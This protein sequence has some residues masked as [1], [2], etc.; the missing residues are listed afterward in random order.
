[1]SVEA[2]TVGRPTRTRL[3]AACFLGI[4]TGLVA[5]TSLEAM[6]VPLQN[7]FV[8]SVDDINVLVLAVSAGS[9]LILFAAG[10][11]A[12]R[13]GPRRILTLGVIINL[14]GAVLVAS[15]SG[16]PWLMAGR[17][18][19]GIGGTAMGVSSM[20]ILNATFT[21][22][23]ERAYV[24]GLFAAVIGLT[25]TISPV[26]GG[27]VAQHLTWRLVPVLWIAVS[28][29]ALLFMRG[30]PT[31]APQSEDP[32]EMVTP[33]AAGVT[34]SAVCVAALVAKVGATYSAI[35]LLVAAGA[36]VVL[37]LQWRKMRSHGAQPSLDVSMFT[38]PGSRWLMGAM[39]TVGVVNLFFYCNLFL[40]YRFGLSASHTAGL[41][42]IPQAA[43]IAGGLLGGWISSRIGST[44]T[45]AAA[46][47][48]GCVSA[49]AFL[50]VGE[51]SGFWPVV[52]LLALFA[53][54]GG[55]ITGTLTKAF[56]DCAKPTSSGAASSWR[57]AGWSLGSTL[58]GVATGAIVFTY[59][60]RLWQTKL[61]NVGV[62]QETARWA[63]ESVRG[64]V[65]LTQIVSSPAI[66]GTPNSDAVTTLLGLGSAQIS[67]F[68]LIALL[69]AFAYAVS[70]AL[71]LVAMWRMR[72]AP[73]G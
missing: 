71:V 18:V 21:Q 47:A 14:L 25:A 48:F 69:A 62:D 51:S 23:R 63:A 13:L 57:Q 64:G 17:I 4:A 3:V 70:L 73:H 29:A 5:M 59:F 30:Q 11:L 53:L 40:Q 56:L 1:M 8:L 67:T 55:C 43:G 33:L 12:D 42:V 16:M 32:R 72:V 6:L 45:T 28:L 68:R 49:V 26:V 15:A 66:Q 46:M 39:L 58:G 19:G 65:P 52:V 41:L 27:L 36:F 2:Q 38:S 24:F 31:P 10:S 7:D 35:A 22:D 60:S 9:L 20:A 34:L 44:R 50:L 37:T 54:P 61:Q